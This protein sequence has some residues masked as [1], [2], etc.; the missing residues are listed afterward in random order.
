MPKFKVLVQ[1]TDIYSAIVEIDER[2]ARRAIDAAERTLDEE[3]W[4]GLFHGE[5]GDYEECFSEVLSAWPAERG[6]FPDDADKTKP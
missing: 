1:R 5:D 4:D 6:N 2:D 3:G